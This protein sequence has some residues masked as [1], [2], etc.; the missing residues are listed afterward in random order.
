MDG[1]FGSIVENPLIAAIIFELNKILESA[2]LY[3]LDRFANIRWRSEAAQFVGKE[4]TLDAQ[5][6][7]NRLL[8]EAAFADDIARSGMI[9]GLA[10]EIVHFF[11]NV[12]SIDEEGKPALKTL[13]DFLDECP[14]YHYEHNPDLGLEIRRLC[15]NLIAEGLLFSVG[16]NPEQE[17]P[18]S[19]Q[20]LS[21]FFSKGLAAYGSYEFVAFGF[22]KIR[23]HF[24]PSVIKLII[25]VGDKQHIGTGFLMDDATLITAAHC[26]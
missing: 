22:S 10:A 17:L 12:Y 15:H 4:L 7:F 19:E 1:P 13:K 21:Y 20:F 5:I 18:Y 11:W 9:E 23:E 2:D 3:D 25:E 24:S 16:F 26:G 8:L 14:A 6:R